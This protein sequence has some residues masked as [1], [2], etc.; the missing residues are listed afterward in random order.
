MNICTIEVIKLRSGYEEL[1]SDFFS[2]INNSE[3]IEAF[4][5]HPFDRENA[6]KICSYEGQDLY[7]AL[8]L[9]SRTII[10]YFML[11]GWDEGYE[12]PSIGLGLLPEYQG[13]GLGRLIMNYLESTA[14][15]NN[16]KQTMLKVIKKNLVAI[17]LYESQGYIFQ[18]HNEKYLIGYKYF[19]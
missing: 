19:K 5:P 8:I 12:I 15:L 1:L 16:S 18:E 3:Y 6:C 13:Y 14:R 4:S 10:G 2:K 9:E 11:R 17:N 7:Y